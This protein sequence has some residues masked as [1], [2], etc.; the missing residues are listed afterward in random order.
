MRTIFL[1]SVLVRYYST[2]FAPASGKD[3]SAKKSWRPSCIEINAPR[4]FSLDFATT[5]AVSR[6]ET[7]RAR[8]VVPSAFVSF[9]IKQTMDAFLQELLATG[10]KRPFAELGAAEDAQRNLLASPE[11]PTKLAR[12]DIDAPLTK[13]ASEKTMKPVSTPTLESTRAVSPLFTELLG[14]DGDDEATLENRATEAYPVDDAMQPNK[15]MCTTLR[16]ASGQAYDVYDVQLPGAASARAVAPTA[17]PACVASPRRT[18]PSPNTSA[19]S[20]IRRSVPSPRRTPPSPKRT[21]EE[22]FSA[23]QAEARRCGQDASLKWKYDENDELQGATCGGVTF[24]REEL[25]QLSSCWA[26]GS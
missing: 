21:A 6:A 13:C 11:G 26:A 24:S 4:G 10:Y 23:A 18:V 14:K 17:L 19:P 25:V 8:S 12:R 16:V 5:Y 2:S 22:R 1:T 9:V 7:P 15:K 20:P 3:V